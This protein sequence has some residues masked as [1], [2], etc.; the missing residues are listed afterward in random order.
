MRRSDVSQFTHSTRMVKRAR[1]LFEQREHGRRRAVDRR[2]HLGF[3]ASTYPR[4]FGGNGVALIDIRE[5]RALGEKLASTPGVNRNPVTGSQEPNH[6]E[7]AACDQENR[8]GPVALPEQRLAAREP[9]LW[10]A[11]EQ[12][13]QALVITHHL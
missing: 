10:P 13:L 4:E 9:T 1:D 12:S 8:S 6:A 5:Q 2:Q 11:S 3:A 7:P